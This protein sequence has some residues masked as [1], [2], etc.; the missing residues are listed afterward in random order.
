AE[1]HVAP[2]P[3][4]LLNVNG[5]VLRRGI[6]RGRLALNGQP[7]DGDPVLAPG[8]VIFAIDGVSPTERTQVQ[9]IPLHGRRP[10]NP[11]ASLAT[12]PYEEVV[13]KGKVSGLLVS[14]IF[15]PV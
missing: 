7:A 12:A 1:L 14:A 15:R 9:V 6:H 13:T 4:D 5:G 11:E 10:G 8:D 2:K 3:G